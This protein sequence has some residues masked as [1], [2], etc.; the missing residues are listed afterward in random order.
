MIRSL[1][2]LF[3]AFTMAISG[4]TLP[5]YAASNHSAAV[6][7]YLENEESGNSFISDYLGL[8][9]NSIKVASATLVGTAIV[10]YTVDAAATLV[11]PPAVALAPLCPLAGGGAGAIRISSE[12]QSIKRLAA[13]AP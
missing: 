2:A 6:D 7:N 3:L 10:C 13:A 8:I 12:V 11:F 5:A 4:I 9:A 1:I